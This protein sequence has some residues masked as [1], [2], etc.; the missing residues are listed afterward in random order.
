MKYLKSNWLGRI[1]LKFIAEQTEARLSCVIINLRD[2]NRFQIAYFVVE[3]CC[4][5]ADVVREISWC[6]QP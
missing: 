2:F 1:R 4:F 6:K 3:L 5:T